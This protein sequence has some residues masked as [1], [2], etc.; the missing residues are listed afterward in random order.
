MLLMAATRK[1]AGSVPLNSS[2]EKDGFDFD[3]FPEAGF[4]LLQQL[5]KK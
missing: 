4:R 2:R 3:G 5:K 1:S